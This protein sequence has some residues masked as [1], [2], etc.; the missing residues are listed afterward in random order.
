MPTVEWSEQVFL[1]YLWDYDIHRKIFPKTVD[2][3]TFRIS[4]LLQNRDN[5]TQMDVKRSIIAIKAKSVLLCITF[6]LPL[7][8]QMIWAWRIDWCQ[9][10]YVIIHAAT[11]HAAVWQR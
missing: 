7:S 8:A 3:K 9:D 10:D 4:T 2:K 6:S 11:L 5:I 1:L